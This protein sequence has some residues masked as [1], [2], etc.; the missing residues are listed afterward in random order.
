MPPTRVADLAVVVPFRHFLL[1]GDRNLAAALAASIV[2]HLTLVTAA[3]WFVTDADELID[4]G[5][6]AF[7]PAFPTDADDGWVP[8]PPPP[9]AVPADSTGGPAAVSRAGGPNG[10]GPVPG[11]LV[12]ILERNKHLLDLLTREGPGVRTTSPMDAMSGHDLSPRAGVRLAS[13]DIG[14]PVG[15]SELQAVSIDVLG[16][17]LPK[18]GVRIGERVQRTITTTMNPPESNTPDPDANR[19]VRRALLA[20]LPAVKRC[21]ERV[22]NAKPQ[23]T[24]KVTLRVTFDASGA[25]QAVDVAAD[26]LND[27][28]V[29]AC[30]VSVL[31]RAK[32]EGTLPHA[33][34]VRAPYVFAAVE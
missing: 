12:A 30:V 10:A 32:A 16:S 22:L 7:E 27:A 13:R 34:T 31:R 33:V 24:G 6:A 21:Y 15:S 3:P 11:S 25:V 18:G 14:P 26:S 23:L 17:N 20:K 9:R 4:P 8:P 2:L 29:T 1:L 19:A 5:I 28:E